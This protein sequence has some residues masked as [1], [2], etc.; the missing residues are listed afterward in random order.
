MTSVKKRQLLMCLYFMG[1]QRGGEAQISFHKTASLLIHVIIFP[2]LEQTIDVRSFL[3]RLSY[4]YDES[5]ERDYN[6]SH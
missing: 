2:D 4:N 6:C 3:Y 5:H 1:D